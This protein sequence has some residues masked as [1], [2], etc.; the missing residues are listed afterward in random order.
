MF[1]FDRK[2]MDKKVTYSEQ[3]L[4]SLLKAKDHLAF[5][6][7]YTKYAG[8][9]YHIVL[10]VAGDR[11]MAE[12]ILQEVFLKI[13]EKMESYD[14]AKGRLLTWILSV[15]RNL[16]IDKV[17]SRAYQN[18]KRNLVLSDRISAELDSGLFHAKEDNIGIKE[19]LGKL[20][21]KYRILIELVYI[22]GYTQQG[23]AKMESLPLGTVKSRI[24]AALLQLRTYFIRYDG[25]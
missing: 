5:N 14:E 6:Y 11:N 18:R 16:A 24:R 12:E 25:R 20:P 13:W 8:F 17:R 9:I 10:Q 21:P 19:A 22:K 23:V 1:L 2:A 3:E 4:V 7:L 15:S